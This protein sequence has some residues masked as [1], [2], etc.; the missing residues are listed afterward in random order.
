LVADDNNGATDIFLTDTNLLLT[1]R[2]SL[3]PEGW[4]A[5]S[6][7]SHPAIDGAGTQVAYDRTDSTGFSQIFRYS[8]DTTVTEVVSLAE[9]FEGQTVDSH[10]PALGPEGRFL[11]YLETTPETT[12]APG[13]CAVHVVDQETGA[14]QRIECPEELAIGGQFLPSFDADARTI[15]WVLS[16]EEATTATDTGL[17]G[18][19]SVTVPNPFL[20]PPL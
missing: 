2:V 1:E 6:P 11:A 15:E 4:E 8:T 5:T 9:N 18:A 16:G 20:P 13:T 19:L 7:A 14:F 10:H 17:T 3:T 12:A